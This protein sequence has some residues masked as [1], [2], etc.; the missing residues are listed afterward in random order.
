MLAPWKKSY[1][2]PR[3]HIEKQRHYFANKGPSSQSY[4]FSSSHV[5]MW[6][7]DRKEGWVQK[8]WCFQSVVLEK[9][10]ESPLDSRENKPVHPKG[11]QPWIFTGRTHTVAEAPILWPPDW[12]SQANSLERTRMKRKIEGVR[13]RGRQRMRWLDG[14]TNSMDLSLS[15][16]QQLVMD[17]EAWHAS[18][19]GVAKGQTWLKWL[20][21][22]NKP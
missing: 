1:E 4:G 21:N 2:K 22:N 11:N 5:Q 20:N 9:T 13:R 18:V 19:H 3:Q 17:R 16:L 14:V 15:K 12:K 6:E 8:N 7:L 10:L